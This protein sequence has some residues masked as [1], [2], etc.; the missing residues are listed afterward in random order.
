MELAEQSSTIRDVVRSVESDP[1]VIAQI[2][3]KLQ[4]EGKISVDSM[5]RLGIINRNE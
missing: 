1:D 5:G 4:A 3:D 2:I